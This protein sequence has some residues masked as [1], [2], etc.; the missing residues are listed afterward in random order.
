MLTES[1]FSRSLSLLWKTLKKDGLIFIPFL[2]RIICNM[3]PSIKR[4]EELY[5]ICYIKKTDVDTSYH[6][7]W[8][9]SNKL[10][11]HPRFNGLM[12]CEKTKDNVFGKVTKKTLLNI[13]SQKTTPKLMKQF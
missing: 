13:R 1:F 8:R 11:Q 7:L 9:A 5:K 3:I 6:Y 12:S 4:I 10:L 2:P